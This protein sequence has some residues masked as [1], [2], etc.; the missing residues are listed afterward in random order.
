MR[1]GK[2]KGESVTRGRGVKMEEEKALL[3][4]TSSLTKVKFTSKTIPHSWFHK[5]ACERLP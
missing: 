1:G 2:Y 3:G 4:T 5:G